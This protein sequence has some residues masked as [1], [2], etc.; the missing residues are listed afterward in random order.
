MALRQELKLSDI[1]GMIERNQF[2]P[3]DK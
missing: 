1:M 3:N 2:G